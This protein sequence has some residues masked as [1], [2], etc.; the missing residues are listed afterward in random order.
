MKRDE[1]PSMFG[2]MQ[3]LT[4]E[5]RQRFGEFRRKMKS[6]PEVSEELI[7]DEKKKEWYVRYLKGKKEVTQARFAE[8]ELKIEKAAS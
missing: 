6:D 4:A 2:I 3:S 8:Q 5:Q 1:Q 7:W